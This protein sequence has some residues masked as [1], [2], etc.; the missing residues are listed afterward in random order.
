MLD[1]YLRIVA[2]LLNVSLFGRM[3]LF[4]TGFAAF[5]FKNFP[6]HEARVLIRKVFPPFHVFIIFSAGF[7]K[8]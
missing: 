3:L 1:T 2:I 5:L 7:A 6:P 8:A 4:S